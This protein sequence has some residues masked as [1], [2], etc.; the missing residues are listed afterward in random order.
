MGC[1]KKAGIRSSLPILPLAVLTIVFLLAGNLVAGVPNDVCADCHDI[2]ETFH[3]T[4][5][6]IYLADDPELAENSCEACHGSAVDHVNEGDPDLILNP[7]D[8]DQFGASLL[9]LNCHQDQQFDDWSFSSHNTGGVNCSA[10]HVVHTGYT[11]SKPDSPDLCYTCHSDVRAAAYMP[12]RHPVAEGKMDCKDC[13]NIHGGATMFVQDQSRTEL[14][15]SCHADKEGPWVY[16]HAP[17]QEDCMICHSP[18]GTVANNL[19]KQQEPALCLNCHSMHFHATIEGADASIIPPADS[20][21]VVNSTPDG[22]K[23]GMLTKC[24]QC[25]TAVHGTDLPSQSISGH[26]ASLT[27]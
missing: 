23:K 25:H 10:C 26:G 12:S 7:A 21:L 4:P 1:L 3:K 15:Y 16:E 9:C 17:V 6:A 2:S 20:N 8:Q 11:P 27:R 13:H 19:L 5:H 14:C 22:W 24:T 18:H